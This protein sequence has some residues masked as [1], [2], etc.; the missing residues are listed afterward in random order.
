MGKPIKV[1]LAEAFE[2]GGGK[3]SQKQAESIAKEVS[4]EKLKEFLSKLRD[5]KKYGMS[6]DKILQAVKDGRIAS[7]AVGTA[8]AGN[9]L[10]DWRMRNQDE[11]L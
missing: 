4:P 10:S 8:T 6:P 1:Q 11:N 2:Q 3:L 5:F 9:A 7:I